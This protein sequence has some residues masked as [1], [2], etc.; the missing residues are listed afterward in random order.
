MMSTLSQVSLTSEVVAD[1][2]HTRKVQ[3]LTTEYL[4][5]LT[6]RDHQARGYKLEKILRQLFE[7]FDLDPKA[8]FKIVGEQIDGAFTFDKTDYL[9]EAKWQQEPV[10]A[11]DLDVLAGR[12][13]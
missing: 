4:G 13:S 9:L 7:L 11:A 2:G 5:P 10:C 6:A 12:L 3:V 1:N 8:S